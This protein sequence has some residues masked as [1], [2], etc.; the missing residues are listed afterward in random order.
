MKVLQKW[1][2]EE[3]GKNF[4]INELINLTWLDLGNNNLTS[5]PKEIGKLTNFFVIFSVIFN[6]TFEL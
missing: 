6:F 4:T 1:L 3:C 2:K 5:L